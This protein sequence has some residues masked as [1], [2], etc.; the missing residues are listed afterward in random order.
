MARC[1]KHSRLNCLDCEPRT[2][3]SE[4]TSTYDRVTD[5]VSL[6][7]NAINAATQAATS[8]SDTSSCDT[9]SSSYSDPGTSYS[10]PGSSC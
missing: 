10:D 7:M 9:S 5:P 8:Y 3:S 4:Y 1:R 6:A 2:S